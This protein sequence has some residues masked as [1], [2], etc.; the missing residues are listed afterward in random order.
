MRFLAIALL[1]L[2]ATS[3]H[4]QEFGPWKFAMSAAEIERQQEVGPYTAFANGDL[5]TYQG[6]FAGK[7]RNFQF[8]LREGKLRR[9][10]IRMYEGPDIDLA[11]KAWTET[12]QAVSELFGDV[13]TPRI[14]SKSPDGIAQQ[15]VSLVRAGGKAQMA[16]VKQHDGQ[17]V[18]CTFM[19]GAPPGGQ[20]LY[21][22]TINVDEPHR[23]AP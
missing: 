8:Y 5:E 15:A 3:V 20:A 13:E 4:A 14:N 6:V 19:A 12:Y 10:A 21:L 1:L 9:I 22:V 23:P 17:V 16:P 2:V 7:K 18:F 11:S